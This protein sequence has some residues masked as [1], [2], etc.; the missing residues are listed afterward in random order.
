MHKLHVSITQMDPRA[1]ASSTGARTGPAHATETPD[2]RLEI[3]EQLNQCHH[4]K[5]RGHYRE[6]G[7]KPTRLCPGRLL[8]TLTVPTSSVLLSPS[9]FQFMR[10]SVLPGQAGELSYRH[11]LWP[12]ATTEEP[13]L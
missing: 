6:Q 13:N 3:Y 10:G 8:Q 4:T 2:R 12:S 7:D 5:T 9:A 1:Q 11:R